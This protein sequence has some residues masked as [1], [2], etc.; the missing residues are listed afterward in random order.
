MGAL[1]LLDSGLEQRIAFE[2]HFV[3]LGVLSRLLVLRVQMFIIYFG[4]RYFS[5]F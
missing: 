2:G 5:L 1:S 4:R 3:D